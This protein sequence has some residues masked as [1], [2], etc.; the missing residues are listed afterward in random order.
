[1]ILPKQYFDGEI[2]RS[3]ENLK[4]KSAKYTNIGPRLKVGGMQFYRV[5]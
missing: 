4:F 5:W 1:M 3:Y 2:I